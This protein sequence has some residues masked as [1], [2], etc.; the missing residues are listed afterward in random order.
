[1]HDALAFL[2]GGGAMGERVR[3]HDW[4]ATP[5][6]PPETWPPS[7]RTIVSVVLNTDASATVMWGPELRLIYND[8]YAETLAHRHPDA[9]GRPIMEV[10]GETTRPLLASFEQVVETGKG[11]SGKGQELPL[12]RDGKWVTTLWNGTCS[13]IYGEEGSV[14]GLLSFALETTAQVAAE[15][16][17]AA[18]EAERE[19]LTAHLAEREAFLSGVLASSTDCIKILDLDG[20]LTYMTEGG[21]RV[22]E[23]SDFNAISGC[24][25]PDFWEDAGNREAIAAIE[26]ARRGEARNFIGKAATMQGNMRWWHVAVSPILGPDGLPDRIL[27]VSRDISDLRAS[28]EQRDHF[29]HLAEN[30]SDFIGM[31]HPDGRLFYMNNAARRLVGLEHSST[32]DLALSDFLPPD[33]VAAIERDVLPAVDRDGHWTGELRFR[34]FGTGEAIPVLSSIFPVTDA[35]GSLIGYG[36]V[37]R[38]YRA[39]KRA[40]DDL[41]YL[42]GEL[43]HRLKNVLAVV[44]SISQQTLRNAPDLPHAAKALNARLVALGA[45]TDVL[46][47]NAWRSAELAEIAQRALVPHGAIGERILIDG[48]PVTLRSEVTVAFALA[49]H[50]LATN[51]A[52]YGALSNETGIVALSWSIDGAGPDAPFS[53]TWQER[54]GP[55]VSAPDRT[56]FGSTLIE[57]SLRSYCG[58][59]AA[60]EYRPDGLLFQLRARLGDAALVGGN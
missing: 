59:T 6:G 27:S 46:T 30:S 36:S 12:L 2:A 52:K 57:R 22:M 14:A 18:A 48:P 37:T 16:E 58:G 31:M 32:S 24:P 4:A 29:V 42:N 11:F 56:G 25:W 21:Q 40:E 19:R 7:L 28:E 44:Q 50:E 55:P 17:R 47:S 41:R 39:L 23:V 38:D 15:E 60:T 51:A 9:L 26:A 3:R 49:L 20:R 1:M 8:P 33:Q 35:D 10:W 43:A 13:P 53:F 45:A 34:H 54:G 5:F